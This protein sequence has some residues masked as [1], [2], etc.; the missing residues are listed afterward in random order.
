MNDNDKYYDLETKPVIAATGGASLGSIFGS[1]GIVIGGIIGF[2][3]ALV[4]ILYFYKK[5]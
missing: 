5:N 4:I 1:S 2:V 3:A